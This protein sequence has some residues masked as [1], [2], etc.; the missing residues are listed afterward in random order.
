MVRSTVTIMSHTKLRHVGLAA[1]VT[2]VVATGHN[3]HAFKLKTHIAIANKAVA[4]ITSS[5]G[6]PV[7]TV[8]TFGDV[9]I[10]NDTLVNA[11]RLFPEHFRAGVMGPDAFP[12]LIGG[13]MFVHVDKGDLLCEQVPADPDC[14][15][16]GVLLEHRKFKA[17]RSID[18]GMYQLAR[19]NAYRADEMTGEASNA[20]LQAIAFSYGYL[21]H[22]IG[23]GFAHSYVNEWV[24]G[25]FDIF[26]GRPGTLFG[27]PTEELQ[28]LAVEGYIDHH[29][30]MTQAELQIAWPAEFLRTMYL[31]PIATTPTVQG[32]PAGSF[33]GPYFEKVIEYR[34]AMADLGNSSRWASVLP[35]PGASAARR[36]IEL[37][38]SHA[39]ILTGGTRLGDPVADVEDY[40]QRRRQ[41][42]DALLNRWVDLSGCVGQN[43][44]A[45]SALP[46]D[47]L[48]RQDACKPIDFESDPAVRD[49]FDGELNEA[50]HYGEF[51]NQFNFS[52]G[53]L[54]NNARKITKFVTLILEKAFVFNLTEDIRSIRIIKDEILRCEGPLIQWG[55]C[56]NA[57]QAARR[58]CNTITGTFCQFCPDDC[59]SSTTAFGICAA[60]GLC[61]F[62]DFHADE[63]CS[64]AANAA[65]PACE[66]CDQNSLCTI[67][68]AVQEIE[69]LQR[70]LIAEALRP[71]LEKLKQA[72]VNKLLDM[73]AGPYVKTFV[74][75]YREFENNKAAGT[76]AWH[77]NLSFLQ[78]DL[79]TDPAYLNRLL[80]NLLD[81]G[82]Q[83]VSNAPV[84][85]EAA[86]QTAQQTFE[87]GKRVLDLY[88]SY[89]SGEL[90]A[91]IWEGFIK[92]LIRIAREQN[93]NAVTELANNNPVYAWIDGFTFKSTQAQYD[94]RLAKFIALMSELNLLTKV[95]GPTVLALHNDLRIAADPP[96]ALAPINLELAAPTHNALQL[97]KL[98]F[99][100][101][102]AVNTFIGAAGDGAM[103]AL[104]KSRICT[105]T[106]H[107]MCDSIQ[108]L[109]DPNH[110]G[111]PRTFSTAPDAERS[112]AYWVT[113]DWKF[114]PTGITQDACILS[115]TDFVM[116]ES[117]A[118]ADRVYSKVFKYP[119]TCLAPKFGGFEDTTRP[120]TTDHGTLTPNTGQKTQG[121]S[122]TQINA[123][124][125]LPLRSPLFNTGE[126]GTVGSQIQFDVFIPT[127]QSNPY[128]V[129]DVQ[130]HVT[131]PGAN[132]YSAFVG[133]QGLT[134][135]PRG[136][137]STVTFNP[138]SPVQAALLGDYAN[139][140]IVISMNVGSCQA[141]VLIDN[142]R[143]AGSLVSRSNT[144]SPGSE[145]LNITT[146]QLFSFDNIGEWGS[147]QV[148]LGRDTN[149]KTHGVA[150]LIV[151]AGNWVEVQ[152]RPFSASEAPGATSRLNL[153]VYIPKPQP[154]LY[155][156]GAIQAYFS[157]PAAGQYNVYIGQKSL[158]NLF[159]DEFN[160]L[161]FDLP[162]GVVNTLRSSATGCTFKLALNVDPASGVF[163][164]D[165]L[166]FVN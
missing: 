95:R 34:N 37:R 18:Y 161:I 76:P 120:W 75:V 92:I 1:A 105:S 54:G 27:P 67:V 21:S 160:S 140:Q 112:V 74:E 138:P 166:G 113:R 150:S 115:P 97:T 61:L 6:R 14:A 153:D 103:P 23:D 90:A 107:I 20:R 79:R 88:I 122:S 129:G 102:S 72:V 50:A 154:N 70:R 81:T 7:V 152:S 24:R 133:W 8:P 125:W 146:N 126:F 43:L 131:V 104:N 130:M 91:Q 33:G 47:V 32:G 121:E 93:F 69:N 96:G 118:R 78:E 31:E 59:L 52:F 165:K 123:C 143:M 57:C 44:V 5:G 155:W 64:L 159:Q 136:T 109:D 141:P 139:A 114:E 148:T 80:Q 42:A 16:S 86:A 39:N 100:G 108:S 98:G 83:V 71:F 68:T 94:S 66:F 4:S 10:D 12:D 101:G 2:A 9:F 51:E 110:Y 11:L 58:T 158:T 111:V 134:D 119:D 30:P 56:Q 149:K 60:T 3:A 117:V 87:A 147:P 28:H 29:V 163:L 35:E 40:F 164:F 116:S 53:T 19:A 145:R 25:A 48:L 99:L 41:M 65:L 106:P 89:A 128:W 26:T 22:M 144:H 124:G 62:C 132:L 84:V 156:G 142:L 15:R 162:S 127:A 151:P 55:S 13:Q 63:A 157:C 38:N 45:G 46:H 36:L 135:L 137:W 82:E 49:I 77:V 73:Y 17:W 85:A